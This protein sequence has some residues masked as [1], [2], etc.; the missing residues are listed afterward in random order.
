ML[1]NP[2][3]SLLFSTG[4]RALVF[5]SEMT[6]RE[7]ILPFD[8]SISS[9]RLTFGRPLTYEKSAP[10]RS[11]CFSKTALFPREAVRWRRPRARKPRNVKRI[12]HLDP[13][14]FLSKKK[15]LNVAGFFP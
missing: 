8:T 5:S 13:G 15:G 1:F 11:Y 7:Q 12:L 14:R 6:D 4:G 10:A 2:L 9:A 3:D